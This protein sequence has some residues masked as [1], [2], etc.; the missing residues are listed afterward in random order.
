MDIEDKE[1]KIEFTD[2]YGKSTLKEI[3]SKGVL[4]SD[5]YKCDNYYTWYKII[6]NH[7]KKGYVRDK[8]LVTDLNYVTKS[9]VF[10]LAVKFAKY[11]EYIG[12]WIEICKQ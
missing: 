2:E 5:Y 3:N 4:K 6:N 7:G 1:Y 11:T 9:E 12:R 10:T 8:Y